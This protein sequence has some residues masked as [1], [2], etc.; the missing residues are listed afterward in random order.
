[1]RYT[2]ILKASWKHQQDLMLEQSNPE[3]DD[4]YDTDEDQDTELRS[5][6]YVRDTMD[7][8]SR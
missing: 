5:G 8:E 7:G 1:M 6:D 3:D 4:W 2:E